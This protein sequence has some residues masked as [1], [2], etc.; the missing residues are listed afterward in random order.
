MPLG[1]PMSMELGS[2]HLSNTYKFQKAPRLYWKFLNCRLKD[3]VSYTHIYTA[4]QMI[5]SLQDICVRVSCWDSKQEN[6]SIT[7]IPTIP[8]KS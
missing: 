5:Q 6:M 7:T 1:A 2:C 8:I 4:K 3:P